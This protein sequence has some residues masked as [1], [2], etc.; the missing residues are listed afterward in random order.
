MVVERLQTF[1]SVNV[2]G[3]AL[4][5][6][7]KK[8]MAK[9]V[10]ELCLVYASLQHEAANHWHH[11]VEG[12]SQLYLLRHLGVEQ[13]Q[14]WSNPRFMWTH[15]NESVVGAMIEVSRSCHSCTFTETA[16]FKQ[17]FHMFFAMIFR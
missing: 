17:L 9:S 3:F 13:S 4:T 11:Q 1:Y 10:L 12:N 15:A 8:N 7:E 14:S 5:L 16:L 2:A 6:V